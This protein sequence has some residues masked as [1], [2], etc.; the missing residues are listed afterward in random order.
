MGKKSFAFVL[1]ALFVCGAVFPV[2]AKARQEEKETPPLNTEWV[3]CVTSFDT[4]ALPPARR[5]IGEVLQANLVGSLKAVEYRVRVSPEYA[6]Y[7]STAWLRAR[8]AAGKSISDKRLL[9]DQLLYQGYPAWRYKRD[10]ALI[11]K[12]IIKLEEAYQ[13][14]EAHIPVIETKPVFKMTSDNYANV[15]PKPP[16]AGGE[17]RFCLNQKADAFLA[18]QIT[19]YHNR[20]Y[21]ALRVY[22]VYTRSIIFED[23]A[24]FSPEDINMAVSELSGRL[25][26]AIEG[27]SPAKIVVKAEPPEAVIAINR[28]FAGRGST[29][30]IERAP[31]EVE[32]SVSAPDYTTQTVTVDIPKGE[33]ADLSFNLMPLASSL[34]EVQIPGKDGSAVYQGALYVGQTPFS[35]QLPINQAEYITVETRG[36]EKGTTIIPKGSGY[37]VQGT[38]T[39]L[40]I[41]VARPPD[42]GR[43]N[44]YRRKFYGAWGRLWIALPA[45]M[46]INGLSES[47]ASAYNNNPQKTQEQYDTAQLYYWLT[48]GSQIAAIGFGAEALF[49]AFWYA[50]KSTKGEPRLNKKL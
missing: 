26:T 46:L 39:L 3:F 12:D 47:I 11:D 17:Y 19:E 4:S 22:A 31:G 35:L 49:R 13:T 18:G 36:G 42:D 24:L 9:R 29:T 20:I 43:V 25:V 32:V 48:T 1:A 38:A 41:P 34:F 15:F 10:R 2:Y 6:W 16:A 27:T 50:Y 23:N 8:A 37:G 28:E 40:S 44:K 14:A 5:I 7:E 30:V 33:L 45:Y 21:I